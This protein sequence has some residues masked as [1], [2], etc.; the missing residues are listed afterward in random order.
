MAKIADYFISKVRYE[1]INGK[2]HVSKVF[3]HENNQENKFGVGT[4]WKRQEVVDGID[5]KFTF[6]TII[7]KDDGSWKTGAEVIKIRVNGKY[8]IKTEAN[9]TEKDNL[10]NL[11][12]Y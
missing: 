4:D 11:P 12:E 6:Y 7:K 2:R 5:N 3:V 9:N 10:E 8:Y 1:E